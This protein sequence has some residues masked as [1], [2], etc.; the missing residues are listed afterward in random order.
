MGMALAIT[1]RQRVDRIAFGRRQGEQGSGIESTTEEKNRRTI[2][3]GAGAREVRGKVADARIEWN[4]AD[5]WH[6]SAQAVTPRV[7]PRAS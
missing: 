5:P 6:P 1:K 7:V 4:G 3:H 2:R